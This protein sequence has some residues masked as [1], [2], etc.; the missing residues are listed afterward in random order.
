VGQPDEPQRIINSRLVNAS[1]VYYGWVILAVGAIGGVLSS[2]GQTYAFSAFL[3]HF[4]RDLDL[5]RSLVSTLYTAGTLIASFFLP[6]VGRR[7]DRH[8]ARVMITLVSLLLGLACI[9][10]SLVRT[11]VMLGIGFFLLRQLGQGSLTLV[12]KNVVNLWWVR[13]RGRVMGLMGVIGALLGGLFPYFIN[14]LIAHFGW[15]W[16]YVILGLLVIG[17][18][19]PLGWIFTRNRPEDHGLHPD[20]EA[21]DAGDSDRLD[22]PLE[23]NWTLA[24]VLRC[25]AFW[26]TATCMS[27]MAMLNTGLYFHIF[28]IFEDSGLSSTVAA[29]VFV[30]IAATGAAMQLVTG[31]LVGRV[32]LRLLLSAALILNAVILVAATRLTSIP[33]AYAFGVGWGIQSGIEMLVLGV[34]FANYFGRRH[35]GAIAGFASTMQVAASALGPMPFGIARDL[36]GNYETVLTGCAI[37]PLMLA[38]AC[39]L[40]G[41]PSAVPPESVE[42]D[43]AGNG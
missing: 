31:L 28:S 43:D 42:S 38:V 16:T 41:K 40:F 12:S 19:V 39:L 6:F 29:S 30:P 2:P 35:L 33:A 21:P 3:D 20:G 24:Q 25:P 5:S 10:M 7:F 23:S 11:A 26:V 8:G 15:R 4:I 1:P 34:I 32:H 17:V 9:Y 37:V 18:M 36:L 13:K 27:A 22:E 14:S